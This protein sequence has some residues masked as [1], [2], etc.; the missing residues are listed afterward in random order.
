MDE[1]KFEIFY[2][3]LLE[4]EDFVRLRGLLKGWENKLVKKIRV[5]PNG[6]VREEGIY[7]LSSSAIIDDKDSCFLQV[8]MS[9]GVINIQRGDFIERADNKKIII[10]RSWRDPW[11]I[12]KDV[13]RV[14]EEE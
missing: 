14:V 9:N 7:Y 8:W 2:L 12:H 6:I 1:D 3:K 4:R 13:L 5:M 11:S 10:Q